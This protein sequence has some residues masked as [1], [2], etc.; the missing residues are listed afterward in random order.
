M[1]DLNHP[2]KR[3]GILQTL[4]M[5][6]FRLMISVPLAIS[7]L[8]VL[9]ALAYR[10][11]RFANIPSIGEIVDRQTE[12]RISLEPEQNA[13]TF[14]E[15][16]FALIP[17]T[18]DDRALGKAV[19]ALDAGEVGWPDVSPSAKSSLKTC[20][21]ILVEWRRG[22]RLGRGVRVQPAVSRRYF[23]NPGVDEYSRDRLAHSPGI[24]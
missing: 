17:E 3:K 12:G 9:A 4:R 14:Y 21:A 10:S 16:A 20:E 23:T 6:A 5:F 13:F 7:L 18:L 8:I 2:E 19:E 1:V 11:S 24:A 22:T 15:R